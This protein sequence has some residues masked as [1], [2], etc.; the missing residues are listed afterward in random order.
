M[1]GPALERVAT[2]FLFTGQGEHY[3]H[4]GSELYR[5]FALF[6]RE[7][8]R[9]AAVID[10]P[11]HTFTLAQ[12]AFEI[13]DTRLWADKF[14]QP[15]LFA[16][17]HA[18]SQLFLA[19]GI[20][21]E[22]LIG[23]SLGEYA[24]ASLAGCLAPED[25]MRILYRRGELMQ[26]LPAGNFMAVIFAPRA[27]VEPELDLAKAQ[28]AA[29]N[30]PEKTVISG[31]G[32]EVDR[33]RLLFQGRGYESYFLKTN[34]AYHSH[35]MDPILDAFRASLEAYHFAAPQR[36]W[37][38]TLTGRRMTEA[39]G[40]EHWVRHLRQPVLF[41]PALAGLGDTPLDFV[42]IGPGASALAGA[43]ETL[44]RKE[45]LYL[46]TLNPKKGE[47]TESFFL[48]DAL[49]RLYERGAAVDWSPVLSGTA[50]PELL[51]PQV[52]E[53]KRYW[54]KG[55][56]AKDFSAFAPNAAP[57]APTT[58]SP[59]QNWH[60]TL[61]WR[62]IGGITAPDQGA[63]RVPDWLVVGAPGA[64]TQAFIAEAK[65]RGEPVLWISTGPRS[66]ARP[67]AMISPGSPVPEWSK[68]LGRIFNLKSRS[69]EK[70]WKLLF[71][72]G[73]GNGAFTEAD[74]DAAQSRVFG[75]L[76]PML[77]A[78]HGQG[79]V[80]P[81]WILTQDSQAATPGDK[82]NLAAAPL[83][84]FG[85]TLL[86]EHPEW[87]GGQI[88]LS[89]RDPVPE[90]AR[91]VLLKILNP[92]FEPCVALRGSRQFAQCLTPAPLPQATCQNF[93]GDGA[94]I[95]TGG[96]GGLGLATAE[97]IA[98]KGGRHL[99]LLGRT[100]H[101]T[102]ALQQRIAALEA[103]GAKI[104]TRAMDI[105]DSAALTALFAGLD[106]AGVPVRGIVHAAGENWFGKVLRLNSAR[107]LETLR[108]KVGAAW[109]LHRHTA[110]R[111]LDCFILFSSVSALWGSVELS[112]YTAAN[113]FLDMLSLHRAVL[114]LPS[115]SVDWG[116]WAEVGMSANPADKV[117]LEKLGFAL[118]PPARA[119]SALETAMAAGRPLS[120]IADMDWEAFQLFIDFCPQLSLFSAVAL[121]QERMAL[122]QPGRLDAILTAPP[123]AAR[124]MIEKAVRMELRAVALIESSFTIDAEQRF[125]FMGMDSLM[126]LSFAAAL[127]AY[128]RIEVPSTLTYNYPNI[129][130]VTDF[131]ATTLLGPMPAKATAEPATPAPAPR[132]AGLNGSP[133]ARRVRVSTVCPSR[134]RAPP[135]SLGWPVHW[136][137][138]RR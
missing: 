80:C 48:L 53:R 121:R 130:A 12:L 88:D 54:I 82:L 10:R 86:L 97:W 96:L 67:D 109:A 99:I 135:P 65:A 25:A 79:V 7:F 118:M 63:G 40:A 91:Q 69:G 2:A 100:L 8:D 22:I 18:L 59:G 39:P 58:T 43:R 95:I 138:R 81:V 52:L 14:M 107:F 94:F 103:A 74:I 30:S 68:A 20:A 136:A 70:S 56:T 110:E 17:Q 131:F 84:G 132:T 13:E 62:E 93:R 26:T 3:L 66:A 6:R 45:A 19:C 119:L 124:K 4:M 113:Q 57:H 75:H 23:H 137:M 108:T 9:C 33:V 105:R 5:R 106:E 44:G 117:V 116:P 15:I 29:V 49:C 38:S 60:Y 87:R 90:T 37:M 101:Q 51:P 92:A 21:P 102:E 31:N 126:A 42:E 112:H 83:W 11:A 129:R 27:L 98:A 64:L 123:E 35:V 115:L 72:D 47:R 36:A 120:L 125:N 32:H 78:L 28:V 127:E 76:I 41:A 71:V 34:Q 89:S 85:K 73:P 128:F 16:V 111:D 55:V 50:R 24:A 104:E 114:G 122:A 61:A 77:Q 133:P 46:R 1:P 134:A